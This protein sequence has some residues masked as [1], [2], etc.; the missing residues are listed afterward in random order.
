MRKRREG[1][2]LSLA[3]LDVICC[4]FGAIILLLMITKISLPEILEVTLEEIAAMIAK[5]QD[6]IEKII[7]E[8]EVLERTR[9]ETESN[10]EDEL[11]QLA[12]LQEELFELTSRHESVLNL[13]VAQESQRADLTRAQQSLTEEMIRLLGPEFQRRNNTIGGIA[14]DS[15]YI[16]FVIDTSG[17]MQT[18][19]WPSV[20]KKLQEV[21]EIYPVVKGMQVMNDMGDYMFPQ[22]RG[23]WLE[24]TM[25]R[26][27][28]IMQRLRTW[29]I[30]SN[31]SPVEG[32]REAIDTY[33]DPNKKV[34]IYVFG[35]DFQGESV[36]YVVDQ[37]DLVNRK[38]MEGDCRMRIHGVGF[39]VYMDPTRMQWQTLQYTL[40]MRQLTVRNCGTFVGLASLD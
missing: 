13:T 32:I 19:A 11:I 22:F 38:D 17:S 18:F 27:R 34:S 24:D 29:R 35:D 20:V 4:G 37:V 21:L 36:E 26:R 15:E 25:V 28:Q 40:L 10:L 23:E 7:G 30:Q 12:K 14:V 33:Y 1:N 9:I 31:S 3:F 8:T 2:E 6:E 39:P 5:R 16:I